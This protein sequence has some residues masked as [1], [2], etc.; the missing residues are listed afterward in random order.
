MGGRQCHMSSEGLSVILPEF[1]WEYQSWLFCRAHP[2]PSVGVGAWATLLTQSCAQTAP[3]D[4]HK[5]ALLFLD[6]TYKL[7][8]NNQRSVPWTNPVCEEKQ[9]EEKPRRQQSVLRSLSLPC[10]VMGTQLT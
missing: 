7:P 10:W 6:R 1:C 9:Q 2:S 5:E 8:G 4:G 3:G